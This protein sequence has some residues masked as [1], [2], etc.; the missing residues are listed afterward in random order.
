[1][2]C[3]VCSHLASLTRYNNTH[4]NLVSL[5][6]RLSR[7]PHSLLTTTLTLSDSVER[8]S[9]GRHNANLTNS[10]GVVDLYR[11]TKTPLVYSSHL[12]DHHWLAERA[13]T[14]YANLFQLLRLSQPNQRAAHSLANNSQNDMYRRGIALQGQTRHTEE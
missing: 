5:I 4:A 9:A 8:Q 11:E 14:P 12:V 3:L 10:S 7:G 1:M 2:L 13:D 6:G